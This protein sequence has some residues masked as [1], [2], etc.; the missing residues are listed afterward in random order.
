VLTGDG[1]WDSSDGNKF[2][3]MRHHVIG[4]EG[5]HS[6]ACVGHRA[7]QQLYVMCIGGRER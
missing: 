1:K 3:G 2:C 6:V 4:N 5:K 7:A